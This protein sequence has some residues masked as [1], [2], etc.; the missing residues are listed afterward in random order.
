M[1]STPPVPSAPAEPLHTDAGLHLLRFTRDGDLLVFDDKRPGDGFAQFYSLE[2]NELRKFVRE[3]V[4]SKLERVRDRD[5][6]QS[7]FDR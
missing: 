3:A 5:L 6:C 4:R 2:R 1:S 7:A